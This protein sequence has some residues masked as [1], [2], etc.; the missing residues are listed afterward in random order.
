MWP[1]NPGYFKVFK[2]ISGRKGMDISCKKHTNIQESATV[3]TNLY[4]ID[5]NLQD[6]ICCQEKEFSLLSLHLP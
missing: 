4:T 5:K 1:M 2:I 3:K 6:K